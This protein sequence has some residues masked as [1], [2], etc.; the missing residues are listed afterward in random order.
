MGAPAAIVE[1]GQQSTTNTITNFTATLSAATLLRFQ[2]NAQKFCLTGRASFKLKLCKIG[3]KNKD[4]LFCDRRLFGD[5]FLKP[6]EMKR[7]K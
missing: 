4:E 7:L 1:V 2:R 6:F 3:R 5:L